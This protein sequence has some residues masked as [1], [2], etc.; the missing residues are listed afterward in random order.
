MLSIFVYGWIHKPSS[1]KLMYFQEKMSC[2]VSSKRFRNRNQLYAPSFS[3]AQSGSGFHLVSRLI[4]VPRG[5]AQTLTWSATVVYET[6]LAVISLLQIIGG[7]FAVL[8]FFYLSS[9]MWSTR[10]LWLS[11]GVSKRAR[12]AL[13][14]F[15]VRTANWPF[16]ELNVLHG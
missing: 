7:D 14:K 13:Q 15:W 11:L 4:W 6:V 1:Q 10:C 8:H 16:F 5:R 3:K 9:E 12:S 2:T